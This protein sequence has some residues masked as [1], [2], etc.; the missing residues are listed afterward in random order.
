MKKKATAAQSIPRF[1]GVKYGTLRGGYVRFT[2]HVAFSLEHDECIPSAATLLVAYYSDTFYA[3]EAFEF[4]TKVILRGTFVLKCC[5][6]E[7][8]KH[9]H[10][11]ELTRRDMK[12]VL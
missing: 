1:A 9:I 7:L 12:R 11:K 10:C 3:S 6:S 4:A 2:F 8:K 5:K